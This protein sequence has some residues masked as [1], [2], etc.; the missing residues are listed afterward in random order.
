MNA[1]M[2]RTA[3]LLVTAA[4]L[5]A[6]PSWSEPGTPV[7]IVTTPAPGFLPGGDPYGVEQPLEVME[8]GTL[9]HVNVDNAAVIASSWGFHGLESDATRPDGT[10][11]FVS[12]AIGFGQADVVD[13]VEALAP[14]TYPFHCV[15]GLHADYMKGVLIVTP[16]PV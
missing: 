3:S 8:G 16:R 15:T 10:P 5:A 13:G 11:L 4:V 2:R 1:V 7:A 6:T 14:G 9:V 12:D